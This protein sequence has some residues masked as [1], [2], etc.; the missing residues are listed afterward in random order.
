MTVPEQFRGFRIHANPHRAAIETLSLSDLNPGEVTIRVAWSGV[1]YKDALAGAGEGKILRQFPLIGGIDVAGHV[2]ES[3]DPRF[4]EGDAV[5]TTGSGLSETRDGGY[6]EYAR[7]EADWLVPLPPTL[8]L[9]EA[10]GIGT[11]GFT[12][13]L[14][15]WRMQ[16]V[17]QRPDMGPVVVTGATGGVGMLAI[18]IFTRAGFEVHAITGK[19]DQFETLIALGA[20]QC[21]AR[22]GLYLGQRPLESATWAGAVDNVGGELL[23][24]LT[25]MIR[26][27]GAIASCGLAGGIEL[28]TTV[29]PFIIRGISLLGINSSATPYPIRADLW[30]RLSQEWRPR[31]LDRIISREVGLEQLPQVFE[32]MLAGGALGRTVVKIGGDP[33]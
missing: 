19:A 21:V 4:R 31:H 2:V 14:C 13:A 10:M 17:G 11:A 24:G 1:N 28:H 29:M 27:W 7:L 16:S 8:S 32:T 9:R 3:R 25:R 33:D 5:L 15:L 18:D 23:S 20:R 6:S 30:R 12:A 22:A 26:P